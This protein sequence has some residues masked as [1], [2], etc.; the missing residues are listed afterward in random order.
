MGTWVEFM[1][2]SCQARSLLPY[3]L[4]TTGLASSPSPPAVFQKEGAFGDTGSQNQPK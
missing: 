2:V 4:N 3:I 1:D